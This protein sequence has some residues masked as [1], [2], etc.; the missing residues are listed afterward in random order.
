MVLPMPPR[1]TIGIIHMFSSDCS[2]I[3]I[4][5]YFS[6]DRPMIVHPSFILAIVSLFAVISSLTALLCKVNLN[7]PRFSSMAFSLS[8]S[9]SILLTKLS[10]AK[11]LY[12]D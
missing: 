7:I 2:R 6:P 11:Y 1:P 9:S 12:H 5:S 4:I 8:F 3:L 10:F